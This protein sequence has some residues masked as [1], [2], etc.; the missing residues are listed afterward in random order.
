MAFL[1]N[2]SLNDSEYGIENYVQFVEVINHIWNYYEKFLGKELMGKIDL[3]IDNA[4]CHSGYTPVTI[5]TL[6]K[7]VIIKLRVKSDTTE[8]EIAV[9]F[10]HELLHFVFYCKYG[11]KRNVDIDREEAICT[12]AALIYINEF[13]K[14]LLPHYRKHVATL[15]EDYYRNGI[16]VAEKVGY[17]FVDLI[18][19]M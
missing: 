16:V 11:L 9:Q 14:E 15:K 8:P 6:D 4:T 13:Y 7:Y 12:A 18:K 1:I 19:L 17:N 5:L 2:E 3:F 10:S